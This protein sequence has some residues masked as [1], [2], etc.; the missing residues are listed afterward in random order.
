MILPAGS[1]S[2]PGQQS[3]VHI[4]NDDGVLEFA[5]RLIAASST[6][7]PGKPRWVELELYQVTDG[8]GRYVLHRI[9]RSVVYHR[10]DGPCHRGV[11]VPATDLDHTSQPCPLCRPA[12]PGIAK[13]IPHALISIETDYH[14]TQLCDAASQVLDRLRMRD[15]MAALEEDGDGVIRGTYS[16]PAQRLLEGA[17]RNDES[18]RDALSTVRRLI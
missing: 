10:S 12:A 8:T 3:L 14:A 16:E 13:A 17:K 5:G 2:P 18:F 4:P 7:Q 11:T 15:P 9:G 1:G 6:E